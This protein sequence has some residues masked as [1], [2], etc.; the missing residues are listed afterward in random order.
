M[1]E[2][3][4]LLGLNLRKFMSL[5]KYELVFETNHVRHLLQRW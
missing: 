1:S 3:V 2:V 4:L 5:N